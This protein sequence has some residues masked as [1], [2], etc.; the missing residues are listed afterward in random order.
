M[1]AVDSRPED[2]E[3]REAVVVYLPGAR[4]RGQVDGSYPVGMCVDTYG[5]AVTIDLDF[6]VLR[7]IK[8]E[9]PDLVA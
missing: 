5:E 2:A 1:R 3:P 6:P 7:I 8:P 9:P 4:L